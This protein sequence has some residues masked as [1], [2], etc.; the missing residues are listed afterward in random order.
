MR[1]GSLFFSRWRADN[2]GVAL[3]G[4]TPAPRRSVSMDEL[5]LIADAW[6]LVTEAE[7]TRAERY[8]GALVIIVLLRWWLW[9]LIGPVSR[10]LTTVKA[11]LGDLRS[12]LADHINRSRADRD[13]VRDRLAR[14]ETTVEHLKR[15]ASPPSP[16]V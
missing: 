14:L 15:P 1:F 8:G 7:A 6:L 4:A 10:D 5:S 12:A 9:R 11:D 3:A 16:P 13:E 2:A